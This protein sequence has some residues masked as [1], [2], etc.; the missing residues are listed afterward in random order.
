M[1]PRS[2][3]RGELPLYRLCHVHTS[4]LQC[5]H[6]LRTVENVRLLNEVLAETE[7]SMRP[8]SSDRGEPAPVPRGRP[9][10]KKLQCGHGLRTVENHVL[11][12]IL[13]EGIAASMRPRSSDRGEPDKSL[14]RAE[15]A[16]KASMRPR[17]SDR[18]ERLGRRY[19]RGAVEVGLQCGHGLRTV[20]NGTPNHRAIS[21]RE[22]QCGHGL[23]T[24]ENDRLRAAWGLLP[25]ASMRPR[26][27]DRGEPY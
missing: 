5:G 14:G 2:S 26:S 12:R 18:G 4:K 13:P 9:R 8:R 22:L 7:A 27:S 17:S 24:V 1:R 6:G 10:K 23:R 20:E 25:R 3:D 21:V 19:M 16:K 15:A 11:E